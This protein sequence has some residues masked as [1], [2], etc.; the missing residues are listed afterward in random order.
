[1]AASDN[2]RA[3]D[4]SAR[5]VTATASPAPA[6]AA[7]TDTIAVLR[8]ISAATCRTDAPR[9]RSK[10]RSSARRAAII[11]AASRIT[12][13]PVTIRLT[14]SSSSTVCTA[15]WVTRNPDSTGTSRVVT[16]AVL[17]AGANTP[18]S[19][20]GTAP[21]RFRSSSRACVPSALRPPT[22]SGYTHWMSI[23]EDPN[24]FCTATNWSGSAKIDPTQQLQVP[25]P[26]LRLGT[27]TVLSFAQKAE[28]GPRICTIAVMR[29]LTGPAGTL[30]TTREPGC[31]PNRAAVCVVTAPASAPRSGAPCA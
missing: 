18:V 31:S 2:P 25:R 4:A 1:M 27:P 12:A 10:P 11:P 9:E 23:L 3:D 30:S 13:A 29:I 17:T 26:V 15:A 7:S 20:S 28:S 21:A 5:P 14:N 22:A 19:P 6:S 24:A 16:A 8:S